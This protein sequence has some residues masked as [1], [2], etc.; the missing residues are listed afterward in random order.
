MTEQ[1]VLSFD[2]LEAGVPVRTL[3]G[4]TAVVVVRVGDDVYA[5]ADR[6]SHANVSLAGG[7]VWCDELE[8]ECPQHGSTFSLVTGEPGTL[9][10]TQPVAVF[11]VSVVD[12]TVTVAARGA[13]S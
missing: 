5:I 12:G 13:T 8:I 1:A 11:D 4:D 7:E 6:C 10:A 2:D 3:V 9:P